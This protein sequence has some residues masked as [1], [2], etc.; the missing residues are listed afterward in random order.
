MDNRVWASGAAASPPTAPAS[1]SVGYPSP[2]DPLTA[3]PA[4]KGGA[5][6]FHQLGEELR[7]ILTAASITPD[8]TVLTQL[9][10]ALRSA[11][12]FTT[13]SLGDRTTKAATMACFS[14]E[15][16]ASLTSAGYQ[17]LP[18]GL[19]IQWGSTADVTAGGT[20]V[21]NYPIA[22]PNGMMGLS[23]SPSFSTVGAAAAYMSHI[24]TSNSQMT[25]NNT[26]AVTCAA[27]WIAIG[28]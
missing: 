23:V 16:G 5:F 15:F 20:T 1:P 24:N 19:I 8:H 14:Q 18:S 13:P 9:L 10:T 26:G 3:T 28:Y 22:F 25:I 27:R 4:S 21:V 6:W 17:K 11:G 2:G 7:A 12:V